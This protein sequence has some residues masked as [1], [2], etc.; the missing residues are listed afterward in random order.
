MKK[1]YKTYAEAQREADRINAQPTKWG[2][3]G[4]CILGAILGA[5]IAFQF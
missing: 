2:I 1:L 5:F 4:A 3:L